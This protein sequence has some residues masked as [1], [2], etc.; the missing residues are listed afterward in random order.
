MKSEGIAIQSKPLA[1]SRTKR[2][3]Y[4]NSKIEFQGMKFDSKKELKRYLELKD[5]EQRGLIHD[6]ELQVSFELA[7]SVRLKG[8]PRAKPALRYVADFVYILN[9]EKVIEDVKSAITRKDSVY[10]I[11]KHLMKSVHNIDISEI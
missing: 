6:L 9:S 3:K 10:R 5:F 2:P 11:K 1:R 7:P 4:G 8:E